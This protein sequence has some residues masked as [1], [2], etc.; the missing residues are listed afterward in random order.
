MLFQDNSHNLL[1][2]DFLLISPCIYL[3]QLQNFSYMSDALILPDALHAAPLR[4][5][6]KY[7][8][9]IFLMQNQPQFGEEKLSLNV[10]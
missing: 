6:K 5:I 9:G 1:N 7:V 8:L 2:P 10:K 4:S 3:F